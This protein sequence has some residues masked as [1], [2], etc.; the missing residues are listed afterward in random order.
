MGLPLTSVHIS[1]DKYAEGL[2]VIFD[3]HSQTLYIN[4]DRKDGRPS[5]SQRIGMDFLRHV[6]V[7]VQIPVLEN[8]Y[9]LLI[10]SL[11]LVEITTN[12]PIVVE[13]IRKNILNFVKECKA[14]GLESYDVKVPIPRRDFELLVNYYNL[15]C[16]LYLFGYEVEIEETGEEDVGE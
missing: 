15:E 3:S 11:V 9:D 1:T 2:T 5:H 8:R 14:N 10:S 12:L 7:P 16:P 6:N 13:S 4:E